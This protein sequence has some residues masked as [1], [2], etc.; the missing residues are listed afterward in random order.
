MHLNPL[1]VLLDEA[2]FPSRMD[3]IVAAG[4]YVKALSNMCI[5]HTAMSSKSGSCSGRHPAPAAKRADTVFCRR[6]RT[7]LA[8]ENQMPLTIKRLEGGPL[9]TN[10]YL[11]ADTANG[12]AI[13]VDAP[14]GIAPEIVAMADTV[15]APILDIVITHGHW[16]HILGLYELQE[17]T[18][19][20]VHGHPD[21]RQR[22]EQPQPGVG[23][24]PMTPVTLAN[25]ITEGDE[26]VVGG[27]VFTVL[28]TPGHDIAHI[29][30][31]SEDEAVILG[32]DVLFP[33]GH[34]RTDLPGSDQQTMNR[35]LRRFLELPDEVRV[36]PGHGDPTT[37]GRERPWI[38]QIPEE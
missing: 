11:V 21:L 1:F 2:P 14:P 15:G 35:T 18:G 9:A 6:V 17:A 34:G 38:E 31:Y 29:V 37:I 4:R 10:A 27:H 3:G 8:K 20:T 36:L 26:V 23:P 33:G 25:E 30:L 22:L 12:H 5:I 13:V 28:H 32:G 24:A 19:A 7:S 16:D